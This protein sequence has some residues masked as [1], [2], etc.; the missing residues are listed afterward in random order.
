MKVLTKDAFLNGSRG[1]DHRL[2]QQGKRLIVRLLVHFGNV[3]HP[4]QTSLRIED[5][6]AGATQPRVTAAKMV[7]TMHENRPSIRDTGADTVCAFDL[8]RPDAAQPY[9][10]VLELVGLA[11]VAAMVDGDSVTIAQENYVRLRTDNRMEA[12][13]LF[14]GLG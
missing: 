5:R 2:E 9:T 7:G 12:V 13:Y 1:D 8:L 4:Q 14:L 6:R 11:L 3:Q 10:P